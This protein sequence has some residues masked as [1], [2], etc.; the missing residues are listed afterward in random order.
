MNGHYKL[1]KI[2]LKDNTEIINIK[3][4]YWQNNYTEFV[5]IL[6]NDNKIVLKYNSLNTLIFM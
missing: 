5:V 6:N 3:D 4:S 2:I 1:V